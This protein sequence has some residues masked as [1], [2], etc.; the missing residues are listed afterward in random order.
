MVHDRE[1]GYHVPGILVFDIHNDSEVGCSG[2][3]FLV[4][5]LAW[6]RAGPTG[7]LHLAQANYSGFYL[8]A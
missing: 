3:E 5:C 7:E 1:I 6:L 2:L 8:R 4:T